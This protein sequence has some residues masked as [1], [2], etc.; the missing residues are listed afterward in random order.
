MRFVVPEMVVS[1][2]HI[3]EGDTVA[4]FG[5]GSGYFLK[6]LSSA[7]G[8]SG[9]VYAC[10]IQKNLVE[11]IGKLAK[12][13]NLYN[14]RAVWCDLEKAGGS[15]LPDNEV[16]I[17]IIVNTLFQVEHKSIVVAEM[18]RVLRPGGKAIVI[19]WS[20][21]WGGLGPQPDQVLLKA[22]AEAL[23]LEAGYT[24]ETTFDAGDHHYGIVFRK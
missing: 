22:D 7:V 12:Q 24:S 20:E 14:T 18:Q 5:A 13:E 19:D 6:P 16:D 10:E 21:S 17:I 4:D 3:R 15:K 2:F 9:L 11:S 23:F 1:H 8:E